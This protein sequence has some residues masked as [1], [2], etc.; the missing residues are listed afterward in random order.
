MELGGFSLQFRDPKDHMNLRML[1]TRFL[2]SPLYWA[3]ES[4]T[5]QDPKF[6]TR[7]YHTTLYQYYN[8]PSYNIPYSTIRV[9]MFVWPAGPLQLPVIAERGS[10]KDRVSA[11]A[12]HLAHTYAYVYVY[13]SS[14]LGTCQR[15]ES[16]LVHECS[17]SVERRLVVM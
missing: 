4:I 7:V 8:R 16:R 3:L 5:L 2:V 14:F 15:S 9:L 6:E 11:P 10:G 17:E 13:V 12:P 1:R